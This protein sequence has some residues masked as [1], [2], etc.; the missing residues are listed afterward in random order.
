[1]R[2]SLFLSLN[3]FRIFK[4]SQKIP[5]PVPLSILE[6][7]VWIAIPPKVEVFQVQI[8]QLGYVFYGFLD[9]KDFCL[10]Y[11][12]AFFLSWVSLFQAFA[13]NTST[14]AT[15]YLRTI[16]MDIYT[17]EVD[18]Y[19]VGVFRVQMSLLGMWIQSLI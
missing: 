9:S 6:P 2:Y 7:T 4:L 10:E 3:E 18:I 11:A 16:G 5:A 1:M 14:C 19:T 15:Y 12:T 8:S 13:E 17:T